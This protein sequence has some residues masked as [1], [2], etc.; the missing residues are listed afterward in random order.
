M[1]NVGTA[2]LMRFYAD[3]ERFPKPVFTFVHMVVIWALLMHVDTTGRRGAKYVAYP[4]QKTLAKVAR[5]SEPTVNKALD[6]YT[7]SGWLAVTK[8]RAGKLN[9][10]NLYSV[11]PAVD[12]ILRM[13][14]AA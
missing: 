3:A 10:P 9:A 14:E 8:R 11:Q 7:A 1:R 2:Q 6:A 13:T 12:E 5:V 4:S